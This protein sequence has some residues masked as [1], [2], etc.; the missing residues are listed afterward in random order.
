DLVISITGETDSMKTAIRC[1][2]TEAD[3]RQWHLA[4]IPI[5]G[6]TKTIHCRIEARPPQNTHS[7]NVPAVLIGSPMVITGK[8]QTDPPVFAI[9][10]D[11]LRAR[12]LGA[13]GSP[14]A[15]S[16]ALD[17]FSQGAITY[18]HAVASSSWTMPSVRNI[19]CGRY[20]NRFAREG[21]NIYHV[22]ERLRLI[23]SEC[24]H[25][26]RIT[27]LISANHL[28]T[29]D[30]G[31][32]QGFTIF[33]TYA[34]THWKQG[35][36]PAIWDRIARH[37]EATEGLP[38]LF[39]IHMM[40]PHDP[41]LPEPPF[42]AIFNPPP[43]TCVRPSLHG[44]ETGHLNFAETGNRESLLTEIEKAYLHRYYCGE[45]RQVDAMMQAFFRKLHAL[46]ML[47]NSLIFVTSDHGEEFGEHGFYQH[48]KTLYEEAI[49][50]PLFIRF[51]ETPGI[52]RI[53]PF[54]V[55]T[56]DIPATV[57][58]L[59]GWQPDPEGEGTDIRRIARDGTSP[60]VYSIL[61][62]RTSK[63]SSN[64]SLWRAAF[65]NN[66]KIMWTRSTGYHCIDLARS[67]SETD[68]IRMSQFDEFHR[69]S[70]MASWRH[71]AHDLTIFMDHELV[72]QDDYP[73]AEPAF[74]HKLQQLG[75][76]Q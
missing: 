61:H 19:M 23:Q 4:T 22:N 65:R 25:N 11:S 72:L 18:F 20:T 37:L 48:G 51:Q 66:R 41:Y 47:R 6:I 30:R 17:R 40:D 7:V 50:V 35:S 58:S 56:I 9:V 62:H 39:Y 74:T 26:G 53:H 73:V 15:T 55:S 49:H 32:D 63:P 45:I 12:D 31:F 70:A 60:T 43:D 42:D 46:D 76:I 8:Q 69:S 68:F 59:F 5:H 44:R 67:P 10:I 2:H 71:L 29:E 24:A 36:T 54:P 34:A 57:R 38:V 28:I 33:D 52:D 75:Y 16:P 21:E 13:Y 3:P 14:L 1:V 64:H 27:V